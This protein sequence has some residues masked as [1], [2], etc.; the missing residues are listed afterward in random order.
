MGHQGKVDI[1]QKRVRDA[2]WTR[3]RREHLLALHHGGEGVQMLW[4]ERHHL[5]GGVLDWLFRCRGCWLPW[6]A[7]HE[8]IRVEFGTHR[9]VTHQ[10]VGLGLLVFQEG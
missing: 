8:R 3:W 4:L 2:L 10:E 7:F 1:R 5:L 9:L 6:L